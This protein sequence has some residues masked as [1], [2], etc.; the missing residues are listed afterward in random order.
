[1]ADTPTIA[2]TGATG[3]LGRR[4]V[5]ALRD[6]GAPA[7]RIVALV[8][9]TDRAAAELPGVEVR[10]FD[11]D[12]PET[13][14]PALDGVD[15]LL[16]ISAPEPGHRVPQ[17]RA[18]IDAAKQAGVATVFYTSIE[19]GDG[20]PATSV[21]PL[22]SEHAA[23]EAYLDESGTDHVLL[24]NGWYT[25]NYIGELTSAPASGG[26]LSSAADGR[27]ASASRDDYADAAAA[28][29]LLPEPQRVYHLTGDTAWSV[30]DLAAA[31]S[32]V[33]GA[34]I[35]ARR[36]SPDEQRAALASA[37]VP[38]LW[39]DMAVGIDGAVRAGELGTTTGDLSRLTGR[40]TTPL[41]ETL[42]AAS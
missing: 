25:E 35:A 17:H 14:A 34:D 33:T 21:N 16:L 3:Q 6:R 24:R 2:V 7:D 15:R 23:T 30:E 20:G 10:R 32:E 27:V 28:A 40:P 22:S 13:L 4:V 18:V 12:V 31:L 1:M 37:G 8:R 5:A 39:V 42:R 19:A 11:Y 26:V 29:L 36:V 38:D 41:I 9:D